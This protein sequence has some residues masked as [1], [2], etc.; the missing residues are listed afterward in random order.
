[1]KNGSSTVALGLGQNS[2]SRRKR[3]G[4]VKNLLGIQATIDLIKTGRVDPQAPV[5]GNA[6]D[7]KQVQYKHGF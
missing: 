7:M 5:P 3:H 2:N 1:M 4:A 6:S